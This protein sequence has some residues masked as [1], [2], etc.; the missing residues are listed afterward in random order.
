MPTQTIQAQVIPAQAVVA[1]AVPGRRRLRPP[2]PLRRGTFS[3][4]I[5]AIVLLLIVIG[6]LVIVMLANLID[7]IS[8]LFG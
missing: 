4:G 2:R 3:P 5:A 8:S 1:E 7:T 6:V